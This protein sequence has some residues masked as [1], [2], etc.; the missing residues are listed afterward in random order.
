MTE[1]AK[2]VSD[3]IEILESFNL[4]KEVESVN[5][6]IERGRIELSDFNESDAVIM[7]AFKEAGIPHQYLTKTGRIYAIN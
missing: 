6:S 5:D 4:M 7:D 3:A 2:R 1:R